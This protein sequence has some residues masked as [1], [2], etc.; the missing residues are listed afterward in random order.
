VVPP[1]APPAGSK[2]RPGGRPEADSVSESPLPRLGSS[3]VPAGRV[4]AKGSP[5]SARWSSI[6]A[7]TTGGALVEEG[8]A[9][10]L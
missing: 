7:A 1:K 6:G 10:S 4:K 5:V 3:K 9:P 8:P 2:V